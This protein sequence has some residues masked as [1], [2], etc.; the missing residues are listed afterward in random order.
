MYNNYMEVSFALIRKKVSSLRR[1]DGRPQR[2]KVQTH[3]FSNTVHWCSTSFHSLPEML[4]FGT[5]LFKARF[6]EKYV[7]IGQPL[8]QKCNIPQ[9]WLSDPKASVLKVFA[10]GLLDKAKSLTQLLFKCGQ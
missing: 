9:H 6:Y 8:R 7:L 4:C 1:H 5:C 10:T 2:V 3:Y